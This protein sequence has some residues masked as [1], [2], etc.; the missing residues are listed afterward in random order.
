MYDS[1]TLAFSHRRDIIPGVMVMRVYAL[2][3]RRTWVIVLY[4]IVAA[5]AAGTGIVSH[6]IMAKVSTDVTG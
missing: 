3:E 6:P 4:V 2:Y 5:C 1:F